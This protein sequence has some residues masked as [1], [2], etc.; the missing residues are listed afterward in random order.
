MIFK[1]KLSFRFDW[2]VVQYKTE[3]NAFDLGTVIECFGFVWYWTPYWYHENSNLTK[4]SKKLHYRPHFLLGK[5]KLDRMVSLFFWYKFRLQNADF[6]PTTW[7]MLAAA[8][9]PACWPRAILL[10]SLLCSSATWKLIF[11]R[12]L[13]FFFCLHF[14]SC[15]IPWLK[16]WYCLS[17]I[18]K[19]SVVC[20]CILILSK[21]VYKIALWTNINLY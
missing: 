10:L 20:I 4:K 6:F 14:Q 8:G 16:G 12:F 3:I 13:V 15:L 11:G 9:W 21:R 5:N 2:Y 17:M 19:T 18:A 1:W 7:F